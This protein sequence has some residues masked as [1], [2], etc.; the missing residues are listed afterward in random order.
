MNKIIFTKEQ[1]KELSDNKHVTRCSEKYITYNKDFK[2]LAITQ[3]NGGWTSREIFENAGFDIR[4]LGRK[5]P[6]DCLRRWNK[7]YK[8]KGIKVL[9]SET[10]GKA[11]RPKKIKD[12]S[13]KDKI[14]RLELE[15]EYLKAE[16]DFLVKLRAKRG[17]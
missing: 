14:K 4:A 5:K 11:G 7:T 13:D 8:T 3:Y 10:R 1:V 12:R 2:V 17:Y 6:T 15:M 9:T 16:N